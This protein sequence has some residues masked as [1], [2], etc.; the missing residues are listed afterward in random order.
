MI[1]IVLLIL[2]LLDS[3]LS[4][5]EDNGSLLSGYSTIIFNLSVCNLSSTNTSHGTSQPRGGLCKRHV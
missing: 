5:N 3:T 4:N 1:I 2:D